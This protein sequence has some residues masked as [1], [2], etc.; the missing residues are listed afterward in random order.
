MKTYDIRLCPEV[1]LSG[2]FD[3]SKPGF[4]MFWSGAQARAL[5]TGSELKVEIEAG[6]TQRRHYLSFEVDGLRAQTFAPLEGRHWYTVFLGMDPGKTHDVRIIKETQ[7]FF[8][9]SRV[10]LLRLRTDG[11]FMPLPPAKR[12]I[13]FIGDSITAGEGGRGPVG[14]SEWLPMIF[15]SS[16]NYTRLAADALNAEYQTVAS[17][18]AGVIAAWN[19]EPRTVPAIYE[20]LYGTCSDQ[21][22]DFGF[23]PTDAVI[24]LGTNDNNALGQPPW[25]DPATGRTYK[26]T[27]TPGDMARLTEGA[28]E[29]IRLVHRKNPGARVTWLCFFP[30]GSVH[31]ALSLAASQARSEGIDVLFDVPV[32]LNRLPRGGMGSRWHP[33]IVTHRAIARRLVSLLRR[34]DRP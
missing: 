14:F 31:D 28:A 15:C 30:E 9:E 24:A 10:C 11:N 19:N 7:P 34:A 18:G 33:G 23:Q 27:D 16:D 26:L 21:V 1:R 6:Y 22:Y 3:R 25:T 5:V 32:D 17:S 4:E 8:D 2:R 20:R 13:E 29:F 12:R